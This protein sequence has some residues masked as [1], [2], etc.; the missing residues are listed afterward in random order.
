MF[1]ICPLGKLT[2][3]RSGVRIRVERSPT[4]TTVP[5]ISPRFKRSPTCT[6]WSTIRETPAII[7]SSVFWAA[8]ATAMPPTPSPANAAVTSTPKWLRM[9]SK[10]AKRMTP[11]MH[12][13]ARR[14]AEACPLKPRPRPTRLCSPQAF[15]C[16]SNQMKATTTINRAKVDQNC[17]AS[18]GRGNF[19]INHRMAR[20]T[21][22]RRIGGRNTRGFG[23]FGFLRRRRRRAPA[24]MPRMRFNSPVSR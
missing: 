17:R 9:N 6:A 21:S 2:I 20:A 10:P 7:F 18:N 15:N 19:D 12:L 4:S 11:S 1:A 23:R 24:A 13:R 22:S 16:I 3:V 5:W 8:R 14:N